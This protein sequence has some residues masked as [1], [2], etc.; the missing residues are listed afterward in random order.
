VNLPESA[1]KGAEVLR[2]RA[3]MPEPIRSLSPSEQGG[4]PGE[5]GPCAW[6]GVPFNAKAEDIAWTSDKA[7]LG[8]AECPRCGHP[9]LVKLD[10]P[11]S[12]SPGPGK[13]GK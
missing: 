3:T 7:L 8:V 5:G 11:A 2:E 9:V 10:K 4:E 13:E 6:C 1:D 12:P